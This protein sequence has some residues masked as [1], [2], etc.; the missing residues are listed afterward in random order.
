MG[1]VPIPACPPND[2]LKLAHTAMRSAT[3]AEETL[4]MSEPPY[5]SGTSMLA[6]PISLAFFSRSR[7]TWYS[8]CSIFSIAGRISWRAN[9]SAVF[10]ICWCS[11]VKSSG[12][13][14]S[15]GLRSS[16]SQLPPATFIFGTA[17]AVAICFPL[18]QILK[19]SCR[20]HAA[21]HAH[22]HNAIL[23]LAAFQLTNDGGRQL[24]SGASQRMSECDCAAVRIDLAQVETKLLDYRQRLRGERLIQL[25]NVDLLQPEARELQCFWYRVHRAKTH[26]LGLVACGRECY[27]PG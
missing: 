6:M 26:L 25:E 10:A 1:S 2:V 20:A 21:A 4:S 24:G 18:V 23:A 17:V 13:K 15:F 19:N 7:V 5:C 22:G 9:S 8:L 12:V 16:R 3:M 27:E 11:S 14:T